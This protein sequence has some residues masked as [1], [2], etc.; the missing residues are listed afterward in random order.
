MG[1]PRPGEGSPWAREWSIWDVVYFYESHT[2]PN[3]SLLQSDIYLFGIGK[4]CQK[5]IALQNKLK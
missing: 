4:Y 5:L 3:S 1:G 2:F